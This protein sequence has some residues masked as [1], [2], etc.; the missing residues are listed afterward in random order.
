MLAAELLAQGTYTGLLEKKE[1]LEYES[2]EGEQRPGSC[3]R[4]EESFRG[5]D[6]SS[7]EQLSR[8]I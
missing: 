7:I 8:T 2:H 1:P 5:A 6:F 4:T 3:W